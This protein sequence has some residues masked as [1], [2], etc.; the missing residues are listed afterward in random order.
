MSAH[1]ERGRTGGVSVMWLRAISLMVLVVALTSP[2][3]ALSGGRN[4]DNTALANATVSIDNG[5]CTGV[6]IAPQLVMTAGHCGSGLDTP[7]LAEIDGTYVPAG[8]WWRFHTRVLVGVSP[9]PTIYGTDRNYVGF[10]T[11]QARWADVRIIM[12]DHPVPASQ[13]TPVQPLTHLTPAQRA[14]FLVGANVHD[15]RF[16]R[17]ARASPGRRMEQRRISVQEYA[18][19]GQ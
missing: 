16:R 7:G 1:F 19:R 13:A 3:H 2:A 4:D 6:L 5:N 10:Y 9:D 18:D 17:R 8:Q 12:L 14:W 15:R 11:T